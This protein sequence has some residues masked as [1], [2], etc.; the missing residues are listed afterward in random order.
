M[1][2]KLTTFD[3]TTSVSYDFIVLAHVIN[4]SLF[5]DLLGSCTPSQNGL[6]SCILSISCHMLGTFSGEVNFHSVTVCLTLLC[7]VY[8][9]YFS[10]FFMV[11]NPL[12]YFM[13]SMSAFYALHAST[14]L[15]Q[16]NIFSLVIS[17]FFST[18]VN[19]YN[20][21]HHIIFVYAIYKFLV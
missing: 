21:H 4:G 19:S 5:C 6:P 2:L 12:L 15:S 10:C 7:Q 14:Y 17:L 8:F 3:L 1:F 18:A 11:S 9:L 13:T 16:A 20:F